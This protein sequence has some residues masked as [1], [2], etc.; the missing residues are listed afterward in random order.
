MCWRVEAGHDVGADLQ[1]GPRAGLKARPYAIPLCFCW[2]VA[3]ANPAQGF[4]L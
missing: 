4:W 3:Y 2:C 1:V